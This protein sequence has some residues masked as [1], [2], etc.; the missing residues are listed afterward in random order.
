MKL[1]FTIN[2]I[3]HLSV[4]LDQ[5]V[6]H[7]CALSQ[8]TSLIRDLYNVS[9]LDIIVNTRDIDFA[10]ISTSSSPGTNDNP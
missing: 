6:I 5:H 3:T 10:L 7:V 1:Y 9:L 4:C 8:K 2:Q